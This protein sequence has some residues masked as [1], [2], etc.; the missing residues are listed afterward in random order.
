MLI[1]SIISDEE[2]DKYPQI[3]K[4]IPQI[5]N[6]IGRIS[7]AIRE[8]K[9]SEKTVDR[10]SLE[11]DKK[12]MFICR[13]YGSRAWNLLELLDSLYNMAVNDSV[14]Y[15]I[16]ATHKIGA[17]LRDIIFGGNEFEVEY[18]LKLLWQLCFDK[19]VLELVV[20]D[21]ELY[22]KIKAISVSETTYKEC[23][24]TCQVVLRIFILE[25]IKCLLYG[26]VNDV[27][28]VKSHLGKL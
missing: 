18:A 22:E 20:K 3:K 8:N 11:Y 1:A 21:T 14:K 4:A 5:A 7:I 13:A 15:E 24:K 6:I 27:A 16:Y 17:F 12:E 9:Y 19:R 28:R 2:I 10:V 25:R 26:G 23:K